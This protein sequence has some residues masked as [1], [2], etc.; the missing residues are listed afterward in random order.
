MS[1]VHDMPPVPAPLII[2]VLV[3]CAVVIAAALLWRLVA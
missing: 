3:L 2:R 1:H